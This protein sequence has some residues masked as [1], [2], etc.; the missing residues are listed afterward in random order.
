MLYGRIFEQLRDWASGASRPRHEIFGSEV[1]EGVRAL[2]KD[3][4][5]SRLGYDRA[6]RR[7]SRLEKLDAFGEQCLQVGEVRLTRRWRTTP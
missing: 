4:R 5:P 3:H 7:A 1:D 6:R 2:E